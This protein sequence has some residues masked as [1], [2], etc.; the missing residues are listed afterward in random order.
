VAQLIKVP[1]CVHFRYRELLCD[2]YL[3]YPLKAGLKERKQQTVRPISPPFDSEM[4]DEVSAF[5]ESNPV[6]AS[7]SRTRSPDDTSTRRQSDDHAM[8]IAECIV[9]NTMRSCARAF[10]AFASYDLQ[11][12]VDELEGLDAVQQRT[13][14]VMALV[15]RAEYEK[16]DYAAVRRL[17]SSTHPLLTCQKSRRAFESLRDLDPYR[18]LDMEVY[19]TLLWHT[20]KHIDL[21]FLA[22]ELLSIEP[23]SPQTW[24]AIGNCFSLQKDKKQA[25][26]CFGRATQLDP[27][28]AYAYT[29]AGHELVDTRIDQAINYFQSGIRAD[30]RHYNAWC[31]TSPSTEEIGSCYA[32]RYG[33][34]TCYLRMNKV[35]M[36]EYHYRK[37]AEIHP[38]N[39]I[40]IGCIGLV[41]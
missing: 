35:R 5:D 16:G 26:T 25:L 31:V 13:P 15:G 24:I 38:T 23:R 40:L 11:K 39:A 2:V 37:A 27:G 20:E 12:C 19:S 21:S 1:K 41:S 33:L 4:D 7:P 36:A 29:L 3:T 10:R 28:C 17:T 32:F 34:G 14:W 18:I 30:P 8:E 6:P 9:Y 22:Q